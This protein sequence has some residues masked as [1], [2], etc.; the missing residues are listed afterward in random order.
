MGWI[1]S[2]ANEWEDYSNYIGEGADSS[3]NWGTTDFWAL[4]VSLRTGTAP[5]GVPLAHA[6]VLQLMTNLDSILK[7]RDITLPT[8]VRLVNATVV[9]YECE[10]WTIKKA[11][12]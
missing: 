9:I 10:S 12:H 4:M 8:K 5:L 3:W 11:E 1:I 2:W 6:N 7:S